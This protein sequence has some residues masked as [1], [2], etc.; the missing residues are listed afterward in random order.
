MVDSDGRLAGACCFHLQ[1]GK[2]VNPNNTVLCLEDS[3]LAVS[4]LAHNGSDA[5]YL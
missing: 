5:S 4:I 1:G 2:K 3:S